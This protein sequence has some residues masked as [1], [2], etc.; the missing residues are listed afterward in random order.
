MYFSDPDFH[1]DACEEEKIWKNVFNTLEFFCEGTMVAEKKR[2]LKSRDG[3]MVAEK[4]RKLK[5]GDGTMVAKKKRKLKSSL[6]VSPT[7]DGNQSMES[8]PSEGLDALLA[9]LNKKFKAMESTIA[10]NATKIAANAAE[11]NELN[12]RDIFCYIFDKSFVLIVPIIFNKLGTCW[13]GYCFQIAA[14]AKALYKRLGVG[15][16]KQIY[17][18]CESNSWD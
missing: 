16:G 15:I 9:N 7:Q 2:K 6:S 12:V 13:S 5:S 8:F 17:R 3:T 14:N 4:K 1:Y 18:V 10:A 11:L